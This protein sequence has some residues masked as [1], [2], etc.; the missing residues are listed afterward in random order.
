[1]IITYQHA[2]YSP[3][4]VRVRYVRRLTQAEYFWAEVGED[5]TRNARQGTVTPEELPEDVRNAADSI[6]EKKF[7]YVIWA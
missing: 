3:E 6:A 1:M 2:D 7:N 4:K 5:V